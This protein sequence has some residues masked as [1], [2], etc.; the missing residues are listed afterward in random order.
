[1]S[2]LASKD[3][4]CC[5]IGRPDVPSEYRAALECEVE[6]LISQ[7]ITWY[8]FSG[9]GGFER[10][11]LQVLQDFQRDYQYLPIRLVLMSTDVSLLA[12]FQSDFDAIVCLRPQPDDPSFSLN[13]IA[14]ENS[15]FML[16]FQL[17]DYAGCRGDIVYGKGLG[18]EPINIAKRIGKNVEPHQLPLD[19]K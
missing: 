8:L 7:G 17:T 11:C 3:G 18:V 4:T 6:N 19:L 13:R 5:I 16:Y 10:L 9:V 2:F 15:R 14:I 12:K 1:M